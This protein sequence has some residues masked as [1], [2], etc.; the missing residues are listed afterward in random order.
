MKNTRI[1]DIN[2]KVAKDVTR[3]DLYRLGFERVRSSEY[4]LIKPAYSYKKTPLLFLEFRILCSGEH[5]DALK[6]PSIVIN[7][8]NRDGSPYIAFYSSNNK[9]NLVLERVNKKAMHEISLMVRE[10]VLKEIKDNN[11]GHAHSGRR[12][13]KHHRHRGEEVKK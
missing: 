7:C 8:K 13:R 4:L 9:N 11:N 12:K 3:S 1:P 2:I 6:E 5:N 10:G